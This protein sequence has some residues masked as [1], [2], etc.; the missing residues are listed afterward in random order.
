MGVVDEASLPYCTVDIAEAAG[1]VV[2]CDRK[3]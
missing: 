2:R 1:A 3:P